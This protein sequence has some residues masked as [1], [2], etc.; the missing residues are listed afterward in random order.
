MRAAPNFK[1]GEAVDGK[2]KQELLIYLGRQFD[3]RTL[4]ETGTCDGGTLGAVCHEFTECVSFELSAYYYNLSQLKFINKSWVKLIHGNSATSLREYLSGNYRPRVL[5][6]L[7]AHSSGGLTA[8]EG[9]PLPEEIKAITE[10]SPDSLIVID[11]QKDALLCQVPAEYIKG[12]T[13]EYRTGIVFLYKKGLY[14][15]PEF[16]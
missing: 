15:I 7:D 13:V 2:W 5:F 4:I 16:E 10:L 9:D 12:Y 6:W 8:N 1:Q 3:L 14:N 11:D